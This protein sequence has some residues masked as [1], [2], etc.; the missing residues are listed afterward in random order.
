MTVP[1]DSL[2][3]AELHFWLTRSV[4]KVMGVNLSEAMTSDRLSAQGYADMLTACRGCK[5]VES[6]KDWLGK[7]AG[8]STQASPGC[9]NSALLERLARHH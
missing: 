8:L 1:K 5:R 3:D 7:Q 2:G 6:C 9:V 4:A